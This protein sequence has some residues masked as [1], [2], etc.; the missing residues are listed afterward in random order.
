LLEVDVTFECTEREYR[1]RL[2][3]AGWTEHDAEGGATNTGRAHGRLHREVGS[4]VMLQFGDFS[5]QF[6]LREVQ[7][8]V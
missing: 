2:A 4:A 6:T 7:L 8:G 3:R 5:E 1:E